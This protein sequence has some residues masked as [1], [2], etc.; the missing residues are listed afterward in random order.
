MGVKIMSKEV[1]LRILAVVF[2]ILTSC[3]VGFDSQTKVIFFTI[4]KKATFR[5]LD[6]LVHLVE[7]ASVAAGY[8]VIQIIRCLVPSGSPEKLVSSYWYL[9]WLSMLLDQAIAYIMFATNTAA[10]Q[11]CLFA[12]NGESSLQWMKL[13]DKFGR[14][15]HQIGGAIFCGYIAILFMAII[16]SL[17]AFSLF[18]LYSAKRLLVLKGKRTGHHQTTI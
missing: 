4:S 10:L 12:L 13:C 16:S 6:V 11:G 8:N 17:S 3:L 18:R 15:C 14:F 7:V 9:P 2:L 1:V 5:D